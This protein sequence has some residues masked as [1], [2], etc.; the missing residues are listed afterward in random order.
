M[1]HAYAVGATVVVVLETVI[2]AVL[3]GRKTDQAEAMERASYYDAEATFME[4][5][6][7]GRDVIVFE[8]FRN[9]TQS[10]DTPKQ[11]P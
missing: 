10:S 11:Q 8:R 9:M 5:L 6:E 1:I 7:D 3:A 4:A 2:V